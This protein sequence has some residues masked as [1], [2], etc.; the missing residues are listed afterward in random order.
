MATER[1]GLR[2]SARPVKSLMSEE[3]TVTI[4]AWPAAAV[5]LAYFLVDAGGAEEPRDARAEAQD[6]DLAREEHDAEGGDA[7]DEEDVLRGLE[8]FEEGRA[9]ARTA[10]GP[11]TYCVW[12]SS[13]RGEA[14]GEA[15]AQVEVEIEEDED[16][17]GA[18]RRGGIRQRA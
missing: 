12:L 7:E 4:A 17:D 16:E 11:S 9:E 5:G 10:R 8:E 2:R 14:L 6:L 13:P 18:E 1:S 3:M 15:E